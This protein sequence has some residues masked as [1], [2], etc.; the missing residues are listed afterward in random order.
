MKKVFLLIM[1]LLFTIFTGCSAKTDTISKKVPAGSSKPI[2]T[3]TINKA[4]YVLPSIENTS[5]KVQI[6]TVSSS[7]AYPFNSYIITSSKGESVVVDPTE[8]PSKSVIDIKPAAIVCTHGHP[9]HTDQ[10]Y[11]GSYDCKKILY[12]EDD[13]K[14]ND[15]HIY[16]IKAAHGGDDINGSNY[17]IV[18]EVDGLRI[19]HM[20]DLGQ[21]SITDEQLKKM[22]KID[23]AF[24]QFE[25]SVSDMSLANEKGF[26]LIEQ[27]N[28][29]IVIPTHYT[30]DA[31]PVIEGKYGKITQYENILQISKDDLPK[32]ALNFFIISNTHKYK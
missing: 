12:T 18:F 16:T 7:M 32:K 21:T 10:M 23:I 20:G 3:P 17:I 28:P 14:T 24:T 9:D 26:K 29:T 22:G 31:I 8:M 6:Q 19:A 1:V 15:F 5:G 2:A 30:K 4:N 27:F 13:I 25:N 11:T